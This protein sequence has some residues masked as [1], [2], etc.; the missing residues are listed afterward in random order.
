MK[1]NY[2]QVKYFESEFKFGL[3]SNWLQSSGF[4]VSSFFVWENVSSIMNCYDKVVSSQ[5]D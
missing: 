2:I 1:L 4:Y 5:H 3:N